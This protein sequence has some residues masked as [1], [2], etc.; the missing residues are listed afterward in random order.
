MSLPGVLLAVP[1][2]GPGGGALLQTPLRLHPV[3][4]GLQ[5]GGEVRAREGTVGTLYG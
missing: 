1:G 3:L 5:L 4:P 2:E